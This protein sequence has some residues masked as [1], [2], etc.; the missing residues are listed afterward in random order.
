MDTIH[1]LVLDSLFHLQ[2]RY[3]T[4]N[5]RGNQ[6]SGDIGDLYL[7]CKEDGVVGWEGIRSKSA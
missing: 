2:C 7:S 5:Q 4:I 3:A 6:R 1:P